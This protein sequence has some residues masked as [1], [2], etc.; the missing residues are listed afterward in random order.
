M[1]KY[2]IG[3]NGA[4]KWFNIISSYIFLNRDLFQKFNLK[5]L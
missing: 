2:N 5:S 3:L 1:R 4:V